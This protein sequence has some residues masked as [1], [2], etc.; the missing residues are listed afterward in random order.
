MRLPTSRFPFIVTPS[1][2][3]PLTLTTSE[4]PF[5][6]VTKFGFRSV[7]RRAQRVD[8]PQYVADRERS[9][10]EEAQPRKA[11]GR[12]PVE[13]AGWKPAPLSMWLR[14]RTRSRTSD[15]PS[16][17]RPPRRSGIT[18]RLCARRL[19]ARTRLRSSQAS[20]NSA[21]YR[22]KVVRGGSLE[23][24]EFPRG[25]RNRSCVRSQCWSTQAFIVTVAARVL[26][27]PG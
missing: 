19:A 23:L 24:V 2:L 9:Y 10:G 16:P 27:Y 3:P 20:E 11:T 17:L 1:K 7:P 21:R 26:Q 4:R 15:A 13:R 22:N 5:G 8:Q 18:E 25:D 14:R 12:M 6:L